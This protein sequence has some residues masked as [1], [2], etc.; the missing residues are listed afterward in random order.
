MDT[1]TESDVSSIVPTHI[2]TP[3]TEVGNQPIS[4]SLNER[5][6]EVQSKLD[7]EIESC[8]LQE[9]F[10][11]TFWYEKKFWKTQLRLRLFYFKIKVKPV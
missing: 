7:S 2:A 11:Q 6:A 8:L 3:T 1:S 4:Q 5:F 9:W 10:P